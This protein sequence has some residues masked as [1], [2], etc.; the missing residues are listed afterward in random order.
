M[1]LTLF[2]AFKMFALFTLRPLPLVNDPQNP[3]SF[4]AEVG[5]ARTLFTSPIVFKAPMASSFQAFPFGAVL[6]VNEPAK[7][8]GEYNLR[9]YCQ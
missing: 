2:C 3:I 6:P 7:S 9:I 4:S 5:S 8:T 1:R